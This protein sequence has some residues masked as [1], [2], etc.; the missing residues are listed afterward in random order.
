MSW[1][2][3]NGVQVYRAYDHGWFPDAAVCLWIAHLGNR[4]IVFKEKLWFKTIV[5]QIAEEIKAESDGL[6]V[7]TTF[8]DPSMEIH[9]GH[10][11][12]SIKDIFEESGVP[13]ESSINNRELYASAVHSILG[14][15]VAPNVPLLQILGDACPYLVK[16][17]PQM[18]FDEKRPL[19]MANHRHD[20]AVVALAYFAISSGAIERKPQF[21]S[22]I[23]KK[24]LTPKPNQRE[25][26]GSESVKEP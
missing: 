23:T 18:Q 9:T 5:T 1:F 21:T 12:R 13:M 7:V 17:L 15:E 24:W 19:A 2:Q 8:C 25:V 14:T 26:L 16:T 3:A 4:Y 6:K 20:H 11:V 22:P 10:D